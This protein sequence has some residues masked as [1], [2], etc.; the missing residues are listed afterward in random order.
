L[1][2]STG[3]DGGSVQR[4]RCRGVAAVLQVAVG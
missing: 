2:P 4:R 3:I 1:L